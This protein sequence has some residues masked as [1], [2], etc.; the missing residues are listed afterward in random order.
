MNRTIIAAILAVSATSVFAQAT[1]SFN[2]HQEQI[3]SI[4]VD[5]HNSLGGVVAAVSPSFADFAPVTA[6]AAEGLAGR[7]ASDAR[8]D[9]VEVK[10]Q[11]LWVPN[12]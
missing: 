1:P 7:S 12:Y 2:D 8:A 6:A 5:G 11:T 4:A 3:Q 9:A 10:V